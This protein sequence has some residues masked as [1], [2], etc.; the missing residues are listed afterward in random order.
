M[1]LYALP[2]EEFTAART[3]AAKAAKASGDAA[4]AKQIAALRR[5]STSAWLV[6][7]LARGSAD[8]LE[9]LLSLGP[10]LAAAQTAGSADDLRELGRQRR[11]LVSAVTDRAV[12]DADR[13][14]TAAVRTEVEQTLEAA[15]ADPPSADAV[16][17]G[18]LVRALSFAG[19][20]GVELEGAVAD[21]LPGPEKTKGGKAKGQKAK[22]AKDKK[23]PK[24]T[25]AER[26]AA[27]R[28]VAAA[29]AEALAAAGALDDAVRHCERTQDERAAAEQRTADARGEVERLREALAEA[30]AGQQAAAAGAVESGAAAD[31]AA[32][33]VEQAQAAAEQARAALDALRRG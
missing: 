21:P 6:N 1:D 27:A 25:A 28:A 8:L 7:R 15:L 9:Q 2:P 22:G 3:A 23:Q 14:V 5:P 19:F 4:T 30:L 18:R 20:G 26:K 17:S 11:E 31:D 12:A 10:A 13:P 16:R 29:E 24:D 33:A 32:R